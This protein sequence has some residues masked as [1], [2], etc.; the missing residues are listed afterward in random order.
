MLILTRCVGE[1][2]MIPDEVVITVLGGK[3]G[4]PAQP[5]RSFAPPG[6]PQVNYSGPR[7]RNGGERP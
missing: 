5:V 2:V 1:T 4:E 6:E 3:D 7:S